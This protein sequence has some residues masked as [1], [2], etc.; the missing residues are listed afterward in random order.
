MELKITREELSKALYRAQGIVERK[1][2]M[3]IL[4][5]VLLEASTS[6]LVV[7]AF[8]TEI[9]LTS[10]HRCEVAKEGSAAMPGRHLFEIV[11]SL[12]DVAMKI[13][14]APN[15][16]VEIVSGA[17]RF[18]IVSTAAKDFP[19]LPTAEGVH[20][21]R[22]SA[23]DLTQMIERTSFAISGDETRYNLG[24]VFVEQEGTLLRMVATDGHRLAL[25]EK[26]LAEGPP[27]AKLTRGVII[28]KKGLLELR[29]L[30]SEEGGVCELGFTPGSV[31]F[32][33]EGVQIIVRLLD[34]IFPDYRQVIPR[35]N[36]RRL[37]LNRV[38]FA[39]TLR[40]VSLVAQDKASGVKFE[41][42]EGKLTLSSQNPDL[43]EA[44]EE[45]ET[46]VEGAPLQ[47]GFNARYILDVLNVLS[48]EEVSLELSDELSPGL[49]K[50]IGEQG[51]L[52]VV[53][54]MRI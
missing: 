2:T 1:T 22:I 15:G 53:M 34:G 19:P 12:P 44:Q 33:R 20:F 35:E 52:A 47:M 50:P 51:Y 28:P 30:V 7:S 4:S 17:A 3:P 41:V 38:L 42:G 45:M 37:L 14:R 21:L 43:G 5:N 39:E 40:R 32:R 25:A 26:Q 49:L 27:E 48:T 31:V 16:Q 13:K 36:P 6:G 9:G 54:P 8:D 18:R 46:K 29:R 23:D 10:R 11:R 24:G